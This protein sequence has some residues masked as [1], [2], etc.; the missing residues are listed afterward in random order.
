MTGSWERMARLHRAGP[1]QDWISAWDRV[2]ERYGSCHISLIGAEPLLHPHA[3][4]L[5]A[6]VSRRHAASVITNLSASIETLGKLTDRLP[7]ERVR[8]GASFHP[9]GAVLPEF[10]RKLLFLKERGFETWAS[11][12]AWPPFLKELAD[13]TQSLGKTGVFV[14]IQ[15]FFG[16][17]EGR[18]YPRSYTH[19]EQELL[20]SLK[21]A[22]RQGLSLFQ[23][24]T[25]GRP[26]VSGYVYAKV[27]AN[28]DVHRCG[29]CADSGKPIGNLFDPGFALSET[30]APCPRPSCLCG[31]DIYLLDAY[32]PRHPSP[33]KRVVLPSAPET[34]LVDPLRKNS[35][36]DRF[37]AG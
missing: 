21:P 19:A 11:I 37:E 26:C 13:W 31:E 12:V 15:P 25:L 16:K 1:W 8:F 22:L 2:F 6:G 18:P 3:A 34:A 4:Q 20:V 14:D 5:I 32:A 10:A 23:E 7:P 36:M 35:D 24:S 17:F 28:G 33:R 29:S 27:L 30:A 9:R